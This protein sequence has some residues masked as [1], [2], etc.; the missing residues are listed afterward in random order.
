MFYAKVAN[1]S[2]EEVLDFDFYEYF[3]KDVIICCFFLKKTYLVF[4]F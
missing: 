2:I 1:V 4:D 3:E